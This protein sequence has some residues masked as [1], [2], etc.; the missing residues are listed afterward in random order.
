MALGS[1][2]LN[3]PQSMIRT[4]SGLT[5]TCAVQR[6]G[7][8]LPAG[9]CSSYSGLCEGS[10]ASGRASL[11]CHHSSQDPP[12]E[13]YSIKQQLTKVIGATVF[14]FNTLKTIFFLLTFLQSSL[15]ETSTLKRGTSFTTMIHN[16][17][18]IWPLSSS[19]GK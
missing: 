18:L 7:F 15:T 4:Q 17:Q 3:K 11:H 19:A 9:S 12:L 8:T 5:R 6:R 10:R 13:R 1:C 16:Q 14:I 2:P